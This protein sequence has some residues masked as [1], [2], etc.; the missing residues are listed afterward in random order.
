EHL[1][2]GLTRHQVAEVRAGLR[3]D[4]RRVV[5]APLLAFELGDVGLR[6]GDLLL[7]RLDVRTLV[8]VGAHRRG[9][10]DSEHQDD[11]QQDG[12]AAGQPRTLA[13]GCPASRPSDRT[14]LDAR[15][16]A[17]PGGSVL[18]L[19]TGGATP[20]RPRRRRSDPGP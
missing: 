18:P 19:R 8:E 2:A 10:R 14:S 12:C 4:V 3:P 20:T 6:V 7:E 13:Y 11:E 17:G 1:V 15:P 9:V 5:P 16:Q